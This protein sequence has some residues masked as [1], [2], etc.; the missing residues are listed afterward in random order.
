[1]ATRMLLAC[2]SILALTLAGCGGGGDQT[3]SLPPA[4]SGRFE[5]VASL[6]RQRPQVSVGKISFEGNPAC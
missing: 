3:P 4:A 1:M 6:L 5:A 2:S